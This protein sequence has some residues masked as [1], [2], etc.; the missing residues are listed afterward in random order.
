MRRG[1]IVTAFFILGVSVVFLYLG[2]DKNFTRS[3]DESNLKFDVLDYDWGIDSLPGAMYSSVSN[4]RN[5]ADSAATSRMKLLSLAKHFSTLEYKKCSPCELRNAMSKYDEQVLYLCLGLLK[6][7]ASGEEIGD[8]IIAALSQ[9]ERIG[10][11]VDGVKVVDA[12]EVR[13]VNG[14]KIAIQQEIKNYITFFDKVGIRLIFDQLDERE[15]MNF[16]KRWKEITLAA[17]G[18]MLPK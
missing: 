9:L 8:F 5:V 14:A 17:G 7:G 10:E 11:F 13:A 15:K 2:K 3:D 4:I 12:L 18:G 1:Q 6:S 16:C